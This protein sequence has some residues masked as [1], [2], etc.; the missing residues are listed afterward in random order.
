[1]HTPKESRAHTALCTA[2]C[3]AFIAVLMFPYAKNGLWFDDAL[4]SQM[5]GMLNRFDVGI[6]DFSVRVS[7]VWFYEAGRILLCWPVLYGFFY[8]TREPEVVRLAAVLLVLIHVG[9]VVRLL[10]EVR[11]PWP[12]VGAFV[13]FLVPLFQIRAN[14]DPI[15]AYASFCQ[16]LGI[17]LSVALLLLVRWWNTGATWY[18]VTSIGLVMVSL[19]GYELNVVFIPICMGTIL[20]SRHPHRVR[21]LAMLLVP[22]FL[23]VVINLYAK[24]GASQPY[25][26]S[27]FGALSA[28]PMSYLKQLSAAIPGS[29][30]LFRAQT[31]FPMASLV[32]VAVRNPIAWLTAAL[33]LASFS[34][35]ARRHSVIPRR[36]PFGALATAAAFLLVPP[37][38][39]SIS[40]RYQSFIGWGDAHLPVYYQYFGLAFL[41]ASA[42]GWA[43][44]KYKLPTLWIAGPLF[45]AYSA[46]NLIVNLHQVD[47]LDAIFA[48][49]RSSLVAALRHGLMDPV[50]DG[51][52]VEIVNAPIFING[53]LIYQT[54]QKRVATPNEAASIKYFQSLPRP[55]AKSYRLDRAPLAPHAWRLTARAD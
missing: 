15:A 42:F 43:Y 37:V 45:A 13:L 19:L 47:Y 29:F 41:C 1:M 26:G 50:Q 8:V 54:V 21:N 28:V 52:L 22:F 23:F 24:H 27:T 34:M 46:L 49:P 2:L 20:L 16:L 39:I 7:K 40:A 33:A 14:D 32:G 6:W 10:R 11:I 18:L 51:D 4:N 9:L 3:T 5:W 44:R 17:A 31:E 35:V 48:E 25:Q 30:Y 55:S 38:L 12:T 53:N 36:V